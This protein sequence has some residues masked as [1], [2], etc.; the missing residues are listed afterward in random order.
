MLKNEMKI[1][2]DGSKIRVIVKEVDTSAP[3]VKIVGH[4]YQFNSKIVED[5]SFSA[6]EFSNLLGFNFKKGDIE[7]DE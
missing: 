6:F 1:V 4:I 2:K 5:K 7:W 3:P